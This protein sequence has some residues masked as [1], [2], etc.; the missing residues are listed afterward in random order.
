MNKFISL[1]DNMKFYLEVTFWQSKSWLNLILMCWKIVQHNIPFKSFSQCFAKLI[2]DL[3]AGQ[4]GFR[5]GL[6][7]YILNLRNLA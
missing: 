6:I 1:R 5:R 3:P 4:A 7:I 2:A